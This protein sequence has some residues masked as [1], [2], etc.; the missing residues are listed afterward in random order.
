MLKVIFVCAP[1][2]GDVEANLEKIRAY[3][4]KLILN[5]DFPVAPVLMC[6]QFLDEDEFRD[7]EKGIRIGEEMM[8]CCTQVDVLGRVV[9]EGMARDIKAASRLK[10]NIEFVEYN[11]D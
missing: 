4:K 3:C 10:L 6:V 2:A 1:V 7:R 8:K 9:T 11:D 5:G